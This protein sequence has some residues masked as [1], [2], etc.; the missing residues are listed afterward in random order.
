MRDNILLLTYDSCRFDVLRAATT[1][2]LDSYDTVRSAWSPAT[3]TYPAHL[4]FFAG[5]LP[6]CVEDV[7][8][9]NRFCRQLF[10]LVQVGETNVV[11]DS[12][13]ALESDRNVMTALAHEG[14]QT[15][16]AAAMNWFEQATLTDGF[17]RFCFTGTGAD[18]QIDYLLSEIDPTRPFFGFINFGETHAP[19]HFEGKVGDCP[20]DVRARRMSWPP[21]QRN[22][23]TGRDSPAFEHQMMSAEFLDGRLPRLFSGLPGNTIVVLCADHG[24]A[25]GEDGYWGHGVSHPT[26]WEVPLAIFRLDR[27]PLA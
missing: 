26:V 25:F 6:N 22:G 17:E 4:A 9:Y 18:A 16:G 23:P 12:L 13:V 1:P 21:V 10:G 3:F 14:F 27:Q 7:P 5:I 15:V 24:D 20:V 19:F 8:F 2:V 11:K